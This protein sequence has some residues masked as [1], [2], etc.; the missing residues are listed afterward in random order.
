MYFS[1]YTYKKAMQDVFQFLAY[2]VHNPGVEVTDELLA[3]EARLQDLNGAELLDVVSGALRSGINP[4][5]ARAGSQVKNPFED[6]RGR[7]P[8]MALRKPD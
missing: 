2:R 1:G 3:A 5:I 7:I 8:G 4:G 6:D